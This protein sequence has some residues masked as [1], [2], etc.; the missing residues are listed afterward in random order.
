MTPPRSWLD[1]TY[2][3]VHGEDGDGRSA[4][5][6]AWKAQHVDPE[7]EVFSFT[8]CAEGCPWPEVLNALGESA[9]L[10][11]DRVVLVPQADNLLEKAK[12]LPPAVKQTL[13]SPLPGTRLLLVARGTLS[14]GPGRIL[15]AKPFSE[16]NQQGRVLKVGALEPKEA[17]AWIEGAA[18][19][20]RIRLE[21]G[22]AQRIA[23]RLGGNPGILRRTLEVLDLIAGDRPVSLDLVDQA[24]F[25][26]G[27]QNLFAWSKAWQTGQIASALHALRLALEDDPS[28]GG[29]LALLGQARREVERLCR[30]AEARRQGLKG[31]PELVAALGLG[32]RQAFLLD[33]YVRVLGRIGAEGALRLLT[34]V[35][36]T[37]LDL[38]GQAISRSPTPLLNLTTALC[39]AWGN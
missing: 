39:R 14:A 19:A 13:Q 5:V 4:A 18:S 28:S 21:S 31:G 25:R 7:W 11:A 36:Q 10:G 30:L 3:L 29:P 32:P 9:P 15:G 2:A 8:V 6:A 1:A 24:T 20:M 37:D 34:L 16:W 33:G 17:A 26:L 12:E 35:N 22:V 38:K 27:E 23:G